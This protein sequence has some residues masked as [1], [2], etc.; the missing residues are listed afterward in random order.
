M[1]VCMPYLLALSTCCFCIVAGRTIAQVSGHILTESGRGKF[2]T[3]LAQQG[4]YQARLGLLP[5]CWGRKCMPPTFYTV[6]VQ[7]PYSARTVPVQC[8]IEFS[9]VPLCPFVLKK[10]VQILESFKGRNARALWKTLSGTVRALCGHCT[11]TV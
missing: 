1:R 9:T 2:V 7:C 8:P 6:P 10:R 5:A 3:I 4:S 11:G